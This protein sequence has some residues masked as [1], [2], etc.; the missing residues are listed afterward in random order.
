MTDVGYL[1]FVRINRMM[2]EFLRNIHSINLG[3]KLF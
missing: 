3:I 2:Y 1:L